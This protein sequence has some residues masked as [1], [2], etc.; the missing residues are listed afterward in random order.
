MAEKANGGAPIGI[1]MIWG[2]K[3]VGKTLFGLNSPFTPI[4]V[5]DVEGSSL[6]YYNEM[7]R[8]IKMGYFKNEFTRSE[9]FTSNDYRDEWLRICGS[10]SKPSGVHYGTIMIDTSGQIAE[11]AKMSVFTAPGMER[12]AETMSQILWG[13]VRSR[14]RD[15]FLRLR[16]H[17]DILILTAHEREYKGVLTPRTNP[18]LL[19][20]CGLDIRLVRRPNVQIPDGYINGRLPF[21]PPK[22]QQITIAKLLEYVSKPADWSNLSESEMEPERLVSVPDEGDGEM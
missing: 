20:I 16:A 11:W 18:A 21:F 9:C 10:D 15:Q 17:C 19:E 7:E 6:E 12:K 2:K 3:G 1:P 13:E 22:I 4:H 14:L 8:L 5:I